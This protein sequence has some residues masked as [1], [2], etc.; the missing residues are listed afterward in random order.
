MKA[1]STVS[2]VIASSGAADF[3]EITSLVG[4]APT[5]TDISRGRKDLWELTLEGPSPVSRGRVGN[6][7]AVTLLTRIGMM[8][9]T[10][11]TWPRALGA[12]CE[13]RFLYSFDHLLNFSFELD[14]DV[15]RGLAAVGGKTSFH[16]HDAMFA[17]DGLEPFGCGTSPDEG[18]VASVVISG[19]AFDPE[20]ATSSLGI[21]PT[22]VRGVGETSA[23]TLEGGLPRT[24]EADAP[25]VQVLAHLPT[26]S[27]AWKAACREHRV[28]VSVDFQVRQMT[29]LFDLEPGTMTTLADAGCALRVATNDWGP[30]GADCLR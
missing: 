14:A 21:A 7:L 27:D 25:I 20:L 11:A 19:P 10:L 15:L 30:R 1:A 17:R 4:H 24:H 18:C 29:G 6:D 9:P 16:Q 22:S 12:R 3:A 2:L 8:G 23:W 5:R 26:A 13:M 28:Q